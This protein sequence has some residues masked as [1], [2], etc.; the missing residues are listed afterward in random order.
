MKRT[1]IV[2]P[3]RLA[4]LYK[5]H[6]FD[7]KQITALQNIT[8]PAKAFSHTLSCHDG[9]RPGGL[10]EHKHTM[11]YYTVIYVTNMQSLFH[12]SHKNNFHIK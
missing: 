4:L 5:T 1:Y 7:P 10:H 6:S 12:T 3:N 8:P 11:S 2:D 9:G